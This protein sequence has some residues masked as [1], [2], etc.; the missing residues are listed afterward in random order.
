MFAHAGLKPLWPVMVFTPWLVL[1]FACLLYAVRRTLRELPASPGERVKAQV[2][3][4]SRRLHTVSLLSLTLFA[5]TR[6][7]LADPAAVESRACEVAT[8]Q[9]AMVL[10]DRLYATGDYQHAG[11]C[12]QA[13]GD[14]AQANVAFLKA[15]GP[16]SEDSA[17]ELKAQRDAAKALFARAARPFRASH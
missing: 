7:V 4:R 3:S 14:L 17:R 16:R 6:I 9:E 10:A 13:A 2:L 1:G 5:A 8:P 15:A 11:D 12:Y